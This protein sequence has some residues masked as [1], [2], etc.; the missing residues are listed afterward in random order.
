MPKPKGIAKGVS[1]ILHTHKPQESMFSTTCS[2]NYSVATNTMAFKDTTGAS[3]V[4]SLLQASFFP[5]IVA[6]N[7]DQNGL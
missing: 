4:R 5:P 3:K 7:T 6:H 2:Y 1:I